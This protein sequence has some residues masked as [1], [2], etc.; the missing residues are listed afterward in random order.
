MIEKTQIKILGINQQG[1]LIDLLLDS[2]RTEVVAAH[3]LVVPSSVMENK[4]PLKDL[5]IKMV[6]T[7]IVVNG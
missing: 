6:E 2:R 4:L 7:A 1:Y 3:P 5:Q